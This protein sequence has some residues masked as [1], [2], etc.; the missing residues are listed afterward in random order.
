[1]FLREKT[2][3]NGTLLQLVRSVRTADGHVQ[4]RI[5]ASLGGLRIPLSL[6]REVAVAVENRLERAS[7]QELFPLPLEVARHVDEVLHRVQAATV[8]SPASAS[9]P[10]VA[11]PLP[12]CE[13]V[14]DGV[15]V[16]Q[17]SHCQDTMLGPFLPLEAAWRAL[18]LE[19]FLHR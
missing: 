16:N 9:S 11:C 12:P 17:V 1:M 18:G 15:L 10:P 4:Q 8:N 2:T 5:V 14:L 3:K 6:R 19:G 13:A 7:S